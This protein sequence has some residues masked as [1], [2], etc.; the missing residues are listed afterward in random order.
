MSKNVIT[1]E[2]DCKIIHKAYSE[3]VI[4]VFEKI[5]LKGQLCQLYAI[6]L[7]NARECLPRKEHANS[8]ILTQP[9]DI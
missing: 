5:S 3:S 2:S 1:S 6:K 7:D 8:G 9:L 4:N